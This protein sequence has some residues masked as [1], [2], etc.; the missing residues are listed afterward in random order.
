MNSLSKPTHFY[1]FQ[2]LYTTL[3]PTT[4]DIYIMVAL[5]KKASSMLHLYLNIL[6]NYKYN[7][8]KRRSNQYIFP[9]IITAH[10]N[11]YHHQWEARRCKKCVFKICLYLWSIRFRGTSKSWRLH[12]EIIL[13]VLGIMYQMCETVIETEVYKDA[14]VLEDIHMYGW[15]RISYDR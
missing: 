11:A 15:I 2:L 6:W 3:W 9:D 14:D 5:V 10:I 12:S 1:H 4:S 7:V 8:D 13:Y